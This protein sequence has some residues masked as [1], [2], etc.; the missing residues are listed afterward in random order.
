MIYAGPPALNLSYLLRSILY[1]GLIRPHFVGMFY[2][3]VLVEINRVDHD[4]PLRRF[5]TVD[6]LHD[7]ITRNFS[8][9]CQKLGYLTAIN[10][11]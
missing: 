4:F 1:V 5:F 7:I 6:T 2:T 9:Q 8:K 10:W 3:C 11:Y